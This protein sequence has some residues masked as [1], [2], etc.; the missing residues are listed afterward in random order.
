MRLL[1]IFLKLSYILDFNLMKDNEEN[2]KENN[3]N[4]DLVKLEVNY[5]ELSWKSV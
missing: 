3:T 2:F 4:A 5:Q 1:Q